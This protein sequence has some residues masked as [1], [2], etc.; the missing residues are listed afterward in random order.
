MNTHKKHSNLPTGT[1]I[2]YAGP[3][4]PKGFLL[5][6]GTFYKV[7]DYPDLYE[8]IGQAY[9]DNI[10]NNFFAVPDLRSRTVF[11]ATSPV[12]NSNCVIPPPSNGLTPYELAQVGGAESDSTPLPDH[13]H[14]L[15]TTSI[16]SPGSTTSVN[17]LTLTGNIG[18][19]T[20]PPITI[21]VINPFVA[22]NYIIKY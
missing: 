3:V 11:G 17:S 7:C 21:D 18:V 14:T 1:V 9:S 20:P 16:S 12:D 5:C 22:L 8:V 2:A 15:T 10:N 13:V 6:D 4:A 19:P